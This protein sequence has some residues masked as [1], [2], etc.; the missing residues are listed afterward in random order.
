MR[1]DNET[2][3]IT[4]QRGTMPPPSACPAC[5][6]SPPAGLGIIRSRTGSGRNE[7]SFNWPA[8]HP[9]T[10][11]PR[12]APRPRRRSCRPRRGVRALVARDPVERHEQRRRVMHQIEQVI[13]P[14]ARIGRPP[15]GEAWPASP[16]PA[17]RPLGPT[18]GAPPFTG[19][20]CG[21][22]ASFPSRY[23]CRPSPCAG[24]SPARSTTAA[25]PHPP[26]RPVGA[27]SPARRAGRRGTGTTGGS[28]VHCD[29]LG[30][31]GARLYPCGI[32]TA[33][34]QTFTVA[35]GPAIPARKFPA[36]ARRVRTA[37]GPYPPD[38]SRCQVKGR[39]TPVPRVLL[40]ATLAGPAPS[41]S[42]GTSRLCQGCSRPPRHHP[43]QAALSFTVLLR[44]AGGE[45]LSPPLESTA[46]HGARAVLCAR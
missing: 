46:P 40:S 31:G 27:P 20:S 19:A 17:T 18:S 15:N 36:D 25:P 12:P 5:G 29:S 26:V 9:G 37:P 34:P 33:T 32:A 14:A 2:Q 13:K 39:K 1:D 30:E 38:L 43:D 7:P 21:I 3:I 10:R 28:R 11:A 35:S 23:R 42:T 22:T 16:I 24:L 41:G 4:G 45:G 44:Q 6:A 8:G